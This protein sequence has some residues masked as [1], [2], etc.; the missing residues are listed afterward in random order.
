MARI[1]IADD[2]E[3]NRY[4]L[5]A[6]LSGHGHD[7]YS[8]ANGE[9]ALNIA[10]S[11]LVDLIVSDILMPVK[12]GFTLCR[13]WKADESLSKIPF[14][15]YTATYTDQRDIEFGS[16]LGADLYL[17]KPMDPTEMMAAIME[18]LNKKTVE[19]VKSFEPPGES[20][21]LQ[22]Y[23]QALIRKLE[24]K[25]LQLEEEVRTRRQAE[26]Q[27]LR[28][29]TAIENADESILLI[30]ADG[31]VEYVNPAF[32]R[33]TG[34][35]RNEVLGRP[36]SFLLSESP[37]TDQTGENRYCIRDDKSWRGHLT[38]KT[39]TGKT[40]EFEVTVSPLPGESGDN[41]GYV[42]IMRDVTQQMAM[43]NQ[44]LQSQKLEAI[45]TLAG[46][47]AH[48]FNNILG[49]IIGYTQLALFDRQIGG[50]TRKHLDLVLETCDRAKNLVD[51]ILTFCRKSERQKV[52]VDVRPLIKEIQKFLRASIPSTIDM[53]V[54]LETTVGYIRADPIQ[55]QQVI[56]NICTNAVY[57]MR[58]KGGILEIRLRRV[59]LD[60]LT[61]RILPNLTPGK[62]WLISISDTGCGMDKETKS[63]IFEPFFT[64][65]ER[66]EGTGLGLSV[67]QG[68]VQEHK[69]AITVYSELGHG[70]TFNL[71]FPEAE[72][73]VIS[74]EN[75]DQE[76]LPGGDEHILFVDDE[77]DLVYIGSQML[78]KLGYRVTTALS[79][80]EALAVFEQAPQSFDLVITDQTMPGMTGMELAAEIINRRPGIPLIVCTG[81]ST[82]DSERKAKAAGVT[83]LMTKPLYFRELAVT[84]RN[85]LP[86]Q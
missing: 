76:H 16:S 25:M 86:D 68:I 48:D 28:F 71:Y 27:M 78:E 52:L 73:E 40:I 85:L 54:N 72:G 9:E 19:K 45:G 36:P 53:R 49:G 10:R 66:G 3:Q 62:F 75:A 35:S 82:Y 11:T 2:L 74:A 59:E 55:V 67:A 80:Q 5:N 23:N 4:L 56:L 44:L 57:A 8:A 7:V 51:Q 79:G 50:K 47:I 83:L 63:K 29:K 39:K 58:D 22:E 43:E 33:T 42:S 84:V 26:G 14:V 21:Y 61:C 18:I 12:D 41:R 37:R 69:G 60:D 31:L 6:L 32:E 65:K 34:Y 24:S 81:F 46:G 38:N 13:E 70:T 20:V 30:D 1:L 64:T 17:I 15:F 77:Q